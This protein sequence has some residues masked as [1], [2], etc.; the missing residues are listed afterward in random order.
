MSCHLQ[1]SFRLLRIVWVLAREDALFVLYALK[2]PPLAIAPLWLVRR[3]RHTR[4]GERLRASFER[5]GPSFIKLGQALSTRA[6]FVGEDM[7]QDL[8]ALRD[9][10]PPF[11]TATARATIARELGQPCEVLFAEFSEQA[12]AAAS[13]AQVHRATMHDG[14]AVAIK[15]LRPNIHAA[16]ARDLQLFDWLASI[17]QRRLPSARRLKPLAVMQMVRESVL[18]ELDLRFEAAAS[19]QLKENLAQDSGVIIPAIHWSLTSR[20]VM[21]TD[22]I[23]GT[24]IHDIAALKALQHDLSAIV[25]KVATSF[26]NQVFRDGFFHAD[27]HPGNLF[28]TPTGDVAAV[29]FGIVAHIDRRER[30]YLA[31]IFQGFLDKDYL[32]VAKAHFAAGYVPKH[33][34][35]EQFALTCRAIA[36]PV[37]D[38]PLNEISAAKL[39]GQLFAVAEMFEMET[40]P[41]LLLLQKNMVLVEA[42][43][44]MLAP[45]ANLWEM[46]RPPIETWAKE[47]LGPA[48]RLR[49]ALRLLGE[50]LCELVNTL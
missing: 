43:G 23:D 22:W 1:N 2:I 13:I 49:D 28:V 5:L 18:M 33:K 6:D 20:T 50:R 46:A 24:P 44:R 47:N 25:G 7:A 3:K 37:L 48:A 40:Q 12:V 11:P 31:E 17:A 30:Q 16:F 34:S 14:K 36:Q 27:L 15:I 10:L 8:S 41:Q 26:F 29:D 35:V 42:I 9:R 38:R 32:R 4:P 21:T 39:L 45:E 19:A